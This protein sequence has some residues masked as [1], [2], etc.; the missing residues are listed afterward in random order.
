MN[1]RPSLQVGLTLLLA[2]AV[3]VS[4]AWA[5]RRG[6]GGKAAFVPGF[7]EKTAFIAEHARLYDYRAGDGGVDDVH[8]IL[9]QK[10]G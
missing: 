7:H 8:R 5:Q 9:P 3:T 2:L 6:G 4:V 10:P 1:R